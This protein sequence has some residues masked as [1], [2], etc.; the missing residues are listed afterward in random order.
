MKHFSMRAGSSGGV[1]DDNLVV[2][3]GYFEHETKTKHKEFRKIESYS[4]CYAFGHEN[5]TKISMLET[6]WH[7]SAIVLNL[8]SLWVTGGENRGSHLDTTEFITL[9]NKTS[10][11]GKYCK[12][13]IMH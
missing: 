7:A 10:Q 5:W 1:I 8:S 13:F 11:R 3:G 4:S 9:D 6:K 2:C 12:M